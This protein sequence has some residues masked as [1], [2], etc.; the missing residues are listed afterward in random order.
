[1]AFYEHCPVLG[2]EDPVVRASRLALS[3]ATLRVLVQ[4]LDLLGVQA[5]DQM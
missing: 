1:M 2:A 3:A 5:P 4:G